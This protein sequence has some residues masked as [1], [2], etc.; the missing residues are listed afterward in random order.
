VGARTRRGRELLAQMRD[1]VLHEFWMAAGA[2][3]RELRGR[4]AQ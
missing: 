4:W 1:V 2:F 3:L